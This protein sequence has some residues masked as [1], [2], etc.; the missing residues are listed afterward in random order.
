MGK[1]VQFASFSLIPRAHQNVPG[2]GDMGLIGFAIDCGQ[3]TLAH[4]NSG[5]VVRG[6]VNSVHPE[7]LDASPQSLRLRL[8]PFARLR[9]REGRQCV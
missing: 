6:V 7:E 5:G 8:A 2:K 1:Q 4:K 3:N 9:A